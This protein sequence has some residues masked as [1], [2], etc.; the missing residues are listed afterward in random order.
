V[1]DHLGEWSEREIDW[2]KTDASLWF[3][4]WIGEELGA[5]VS[6]ALGIRCRYGGA[7]RE[8]NDVEDRWGRISMARAPILVPPAVEFGFR[9]KPQL[10]EISRTISLN[11]ALPA[12]LARYGELTPPTAVALVRAARFYEE[13]VWVADLDPQLSWLRLVTAVEAAAAKWEGNLPDRPTE[14]IHIA[15]PDL[16]AKLE[17]PGTAFFEDVAIILAPLVR[18]GRRFRAFA[19][20]FMPQP[21]PRR[22]PPM[23][24]VDWARMSE[25]LSKIYSHRSKALHEGI[26][27]PASMCEIPNKWGADWDAPAERPLAPT[28]TSGAVW[29]PEAAPMLLHVFEYIAKATLQGWWQAASA[30]DS[31]LGSSA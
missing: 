19:E 2:S 20:A 9:R 13:A 14:W 8:Y 18:S 1:H 30:S 25:H 26:P 6:L 28:A 23:A 12:Y 22:P 31:A 7:I 3:G 24:Q 21:L 16:A 17:Q 10:P 27:F 4:G 5:L 15:W 29:L 11:E